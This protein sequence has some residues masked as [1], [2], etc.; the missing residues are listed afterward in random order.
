[1]DRG[2]WRAAVRGVAESDT[3]ERLSTHTPLRFFFPSRSNDLIFS[4][5]NLHGFIHPHRT[6]RKEPLS[7]Q[8]KGPKITVG[9]PL[10]A[11][12]PGTAPTSAMLCHITAAPN[13]R[14]SHTW[15]VGMPVS[16]HPE[17]IFF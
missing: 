5:R 9:Q 8:G 12:P 17:Y 3:T 4:N 10:H 7:P 16:L 11:Q 14:Q 13:S 6:S 2:A 1:M 15:A